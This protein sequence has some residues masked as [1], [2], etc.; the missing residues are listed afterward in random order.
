MTARLEVRTLSV[1]CSESTILDSVSLDVEAGSVTG[2]VGAN[3]AGKTTLVEAISGFVPTSSGTVLLDGAPIDGLAPHRRARLGL[4]R[5]FQSLELF[6]DLTVEENLAVASG[7]RRSSSRNRPGERSAGLPGGPGLDDLAH[8]APAALSHSERSRVALARAV[9]GGPCVLLLDEPAAGLD[10]GQRAALG[11]SLRSLAGDGM[12]VLVVEHDLELVFDLCDRVYVLDAGRVLAAGAPGEVASD[13]R[14]VDLGLGHPAA[15]AGP[16]VARTR[17]GTTAPGASPI[18]PPSGSTALQ[19]E[20][21]AVSYGRVPA[22]VD[23]S[24]EVRGGEV[25]ALAGPNGAGKTTTLLAVA[26]ALRPDAGTVQVLGMDT[27]GRPA[28]A[29][30]AQG[31]TLVPQDGAVFDT[32]T[33]AEN[34]ALAVP[35]G[36]LGRSG[37]EAAIV[38]GAVALVPELAGLLGR[39]AASLSGGQRRL[40]ALARAM[41]S[42]PDVLLVDE[43]TMGLSPSAADRVRAMVADVAS[44]GTAVLVV[45]QQPRLHTTLATR[46]YVMDRGRVTGTA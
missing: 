39:R 12:A 31:L 35:R 18:A 23:A 4:G 25:V 14:V 1:A 43:L 45:D 7:A 2:L 32:L 28:H 19:V 3:G 26:G 10:A 13:T 15:P 5:T 46:T 11:R 33:V 38:D 24:F 20:N 30:A 41:A 42:A 37:R 27:A 8:R 36:G 21:L 9:A 6:D 40:L 34:L 22:V 29:T 16:S 17:P 44:A